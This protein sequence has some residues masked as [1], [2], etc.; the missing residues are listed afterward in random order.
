M[1]STLLTISRFTI[2]AWV[3]AATLFVV[4]GI[5][6]VTSTE[7]A[8]NVPAVKDTLVII[9]FPAYYGFGFALV[10][11]SLLAALGT[12]RLLSPG[13]RRWVICLLLLA[14]GMMIADYFLIYQPLLDMIT[15][16]G[17][18]RTEKFKIY[19]NASKYVNAADVAICFVAAL[20]VCRPVQTDNQHKP[21]AQANA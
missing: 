13:R 4:T 15:P 1:Q 18:T 19:H 7:P 20:I 10:G 9:R 11:V 17:A 3:G 14:L 21:E 8:V 2:A 5:R 16:P 6:E 12:G